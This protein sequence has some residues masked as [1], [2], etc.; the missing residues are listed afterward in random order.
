MKNRFLKLIVID[1]ITSFISWIIFFCFRKIIIEHSEI[2]FTTPF[3]TGIIV[4]PFFWL[5]L[6]ALQGTYIQVKRIYRTQILIFTLTASLIGSTTIFFALILDDKILN[7]SE[8]YISLM[9]LFL[10]HFTILSIS[11]LLFIWI[12]VHRIQ[13]NKDGFNTLFIGGIVKIDQLLDE[14]NTLPKSI[15]VINIGYLD[16]PNNKKEPEINGKSTYLGSTDNLES[17]LL[18]KSIE[19]IIICLDNNDHKSLNPLIARI[20]GKGIRIKII[21]DTYDFLTGNLKINNIY[22]AL[23]LELKESEMPLWQQSTKRLIDIV[24]S[25]FSILFL[26]PIYILISIGIKRSSKGPIL[27]TQERIGKNGKAFKIIKFRTMIVNAEKNGPQLSSSYDSRITPFGKFLR[28][29]RLDEFPQFFNVLLGDMSLVGPRPER[30]HYINLIT[31]KEPQYSLLTSVKP[32]ITSWGQVK[33]GYAENVK[34]MLQRMKYDLLYIKN[35]TLILD[36]KIMFYTLIT[37]LK[38]KGK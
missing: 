15:G 10:I 27:F 35:R 25:F 4:I 20:S 26:I 12:Q 2:K 37:I 30:Q 3:Y 6:Y 17:I 11:R 31:E 21:P 28:K 32:G 5:L 38:A 9:S 16:L 13:H 34:E 18:S 36:F 7:Y 14:I 8:Y 33:Y 1:F 23:L 22:G 29:T 24:I 19:D